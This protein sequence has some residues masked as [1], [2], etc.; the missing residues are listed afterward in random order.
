M[1]KSY[2]KQFMDV[3]DK[4]SKEYML[5]LPD[6]EIP[7]Y[8]VNKNAILRNV[9]IPS[10][11]K[12]EGLKGKTK[13]IAIIQYAL[14]IPWTGNMGPMLAFVFSWGG[15]WAYVYNVQFPNCSEYGSVGL[16]LIKGSAGLRL[17]DFSFRIMGDYR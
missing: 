9:D 8:T 6:Y 12:S 2:K 11:I 15:P 16:Y 17:P 3:L 14:E 10:I 7:I 5:K 1:A 13:P 4:V